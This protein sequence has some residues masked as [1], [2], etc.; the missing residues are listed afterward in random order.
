MKAG[1]RE[2]AL[3][4]SALPRTLAAHE[5]HVHDE[6]APQ[7][8]EAEVKAEAMADGPRLA[9]NSARIELVAVR[10]ADG[11]L[12]VYADER[13]SNAPLAKAQLRL[14]VGSRS[15]QA[16]ETAAGSWQLDA[17]VL[18][19]ATQPVRYELQGEGWVASFE[20]PLPAPPPVKA[21]A[22]AA[23]RTGGG[24]AAGLSLVLLPM[25][26]LRRRARRAR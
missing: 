17:A 8:I 1:L 4:A 3:L 12:S 13:A 22:T 21:V 7:A 15:L 11:G 24:S 5:G 19:D 10:E 18:G 9:L 14:V 2:L 20:A 16:S 6:A 26:L 25:L 23:G